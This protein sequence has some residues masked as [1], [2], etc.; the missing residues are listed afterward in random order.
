[1]QSDFTNAL[2]KS[3]ASTTCGDFAVTSRTHSKQ[4]F[5]KLQT[6]ET[7][8]FQIGEYALGK[9]FSAEQTNATTSHELLIGLGDFLFCDSPIHFASLFYD[10]ATPKMGG[11]T[12][13]G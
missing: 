13:Q 12:R 9:K 10:V 4:E 1:M 8:G 6:L 3:S 11:C 2:D 7:H 5:A